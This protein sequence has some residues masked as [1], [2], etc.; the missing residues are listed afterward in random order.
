MTATNLTDT[1][2]KELTALLRS[3]SAISEI[4]SQMPV[5]EFLA[6][7]HVA[8][9]PNQGPDEYSKAIGVPD[10]TMSRWLL[11]L[12]HQGRGAT[13]TQL[14]AWRP[15]PENLRRKEYFLTGKGT[16]L[17]NKFLTA[18]SAIGRA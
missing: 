11:D 9:D 1:E 2:R 16:A 14:L 10:S 12:S 8:L 6:L 18:F 17:L 7:L 3:V 5:G 4:N 13:T 15:K